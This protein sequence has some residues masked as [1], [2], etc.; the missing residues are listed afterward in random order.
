MSGSAAVT[1]PLLNIGT[2]FEVAANAAAGTTLRP[3]FNYASGDVPF[4]LAAF[5]FEDVGATAYLVS[6]IS[7]VYISVL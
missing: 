2:A 1:R 7:T 5:I 3:A 6:T 4:F